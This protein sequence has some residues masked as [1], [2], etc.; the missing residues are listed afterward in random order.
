MDHVKNPPE[1]L[2]SEN[3]KE[4]LEY[5]KEDMEK[6]INYSEHISKSTNNVKDYV[7]FLSEVFGANLSL[8]DYEKLSSSDREQILKSEKRKSKI[9]EIL[10]DK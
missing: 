8:V 7:E 2:S 6:I 4:Y 1:D 9:K 5:L 10:N 3:V